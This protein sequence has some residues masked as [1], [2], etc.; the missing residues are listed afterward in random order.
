MLLTH[1]NIGINDEFENVVSLTCSQ[2]I[3]SHTKYPHSKMYETAQDQLGV[4]GSTC[5]QGHTNQ[6]ASLQERAD[7]NGD[8]A[9]FERSL[10]G[11]V[12]DVQL[13]SRKFPVVF[14][15]KYLTHWVNSH[16]MTIMS[17]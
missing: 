15:R 5:F 16:K 3:S 9:W 10:A 1:L 17:L 11:H 2:Q 6:N 13:S 4:R 12:E 7:R 8:L 14:N